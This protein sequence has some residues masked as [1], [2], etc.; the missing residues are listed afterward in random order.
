MSSPI[1][2]SNFDLV[3]NFPSARLWYHFAQLCAIPRPSK[4]EHRVIEY[5]Q[6]FAGKH[7]LAFTKD[8][9]NNVL[10]KRPGSGK[11]VNAPPV[12]IQGHIDM[13]TEKNASKVH[14]FFSDPIE[15]TL[16]GDWLHANGTT[17]GADN[18]IGVCAA[19]ALL[20]EP[21]TINLPPLECLFT[22]DEETGLTGA[23]G[24]QPDVL[25][26]TS[27]TLLNLDT[28]E[29]GTVYIGCA[30]GGDST[31]TLPVITTSPAPQSKELLLT[32]NGLLGGHSGAMIHTYRGN[33]VQ[34]IAQVLRHMPVE[35]QLLQIQGG[36]KRNAI[37]REATARILV[38]EASV[39]R[40][41]AYIRD[42][43]AYISQIYPNETSV[44][45]SSSSVNT[46][47]TQ[48]P[49]DDGCKNKLIGLLIALPHGPQKMCHLICDP[50]VNKC[51]TLCSLLC[52]A[53]HCVRQAT[54]S[55][56]FASTMKE[57]LVSL[58][59]LV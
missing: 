12:I 22:V 16:K 6:E 19:L 34:L 58:A 23:K 50:E 21:D 52:R 35:Y 41:S 4:H 14:D 24:L 2:A 11:G 36:D 45:L 47:T 13:V 55:H 39:E 33:A 49:M 54:T 10:I 44:N 27:T 57:I 43:A 9:A 15:L 46:P 31:I 37:A 26:I 40:V 25:G 18:G 51:F 28:E 3:K 20:E 42:R 38:S 56:L 7:S 30:G 32:L 17:L 29:W 5:L 59:L 1:I 8:S 53:M 48:Q